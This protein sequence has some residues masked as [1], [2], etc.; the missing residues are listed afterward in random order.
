MNP[1]Q[2]FL[3]AQ[4]AHYDR[5][6]AADEVVT[7]P[8]L[9]AMIQA[10]CYPPPFIF[11][12]IEKYAERVTDIYC[13]LLLSYIEGEILYI[14]REM[15]DEKHDKT[16]LLDHWECPGYGQAAPLYAEQIPLDT[17]VKLAAENQVGQDCGVK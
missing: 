9:Q 11:N 4:K 2:K 6:I 5:K 16:H 7:L 8:L 15:N 1:L 10:R 14:V 17:F 13:R 3:E 12:K